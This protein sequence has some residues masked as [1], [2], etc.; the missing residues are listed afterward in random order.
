MQIRVFTKLKSIRILIRQE[1]RDGDN[2]KRREANVTIVYSTF[3]VTRDSESPSFCMVREA[4]SRETGRGFIT[5]KLR[6]YIEK[7]E[8]S[9]SVNG[10]QE[11]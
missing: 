7:N 9:E 6:K 4:T 1:V 5:A 2:K 3:D 8:S 11:V 10:V